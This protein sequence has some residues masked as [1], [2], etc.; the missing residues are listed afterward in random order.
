MTAENYA[1]QLLSFCELARAHLVLYRLRPFWMNPSR[2]FELTLWE[3]GAFWLI[4]LA[5]LWWLGRHYYEFKKSHRDSLLQY[6]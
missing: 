1:R 6:I 2:F 3:T 4:G 5:I